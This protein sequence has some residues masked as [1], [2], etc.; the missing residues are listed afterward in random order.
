[1][2]PVGSHRKLVCFRDG[3]FH[4][5]NRIDKKCPVCGEP[6]ADLSDG[7]DAAIVKAKVERERRRRRRFSAWI[8]IN[9]AI[10]A[11]LLLTLGAGFPLLLGMVISFLLLHFGISSALALRRPAGWEAI[12]K[13]FKPER[14]Q[15]TRRILLSTPVLAAAMAFTAHLVVALLHETQRAAPATDR[16]LRTWLAGTIQAGAEE[17]IGYTYDFG[18]LDFLM[19]VALALGFIGLRVDLR[20]GRRMAFLLMAMATASGVL[21]QFLLT[22]PAIT[23]TLLSSCALFGFF[24]AILALMPTSATV[25]SLYHAPIRVPTM[26]QVPVLVATFWIVGARLAIDVPWCG[27]LVSFAV[28]L[29]MGLALRRVPKSDDHRSYERMRM[30]EI[31]AAGA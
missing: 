22:P 3:L 7:E 4:T 19:L 23:V 11:S 31:D 27:Q 13:E 6:L 9:V 20:I 29:S 17:V 16:D 1:M 8:S 10:V 24:G 12:E 30:S 2:V 15:L 21:G 18:G 5:R 26:V 28:G 25:L 14:S